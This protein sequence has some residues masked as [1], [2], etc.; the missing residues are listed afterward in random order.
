MP[1]FQKYDY[2]RQKST[3]WRVEIHSIFYLHCWLPE[4][5]G[6][7][8]GTHM[9]PF[10]QAEKTEKHLQSEEIWQWHDSREKV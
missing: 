1:H 10:H 3:L 5:D 2:N 4:S 9:K 7:H 6:Q 8:L